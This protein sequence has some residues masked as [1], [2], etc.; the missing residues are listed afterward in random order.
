MRTWVKALDWIG[1]AIFG[2]GALA[3]ARYPQA[4]P[5]VMAIHLLPLGTAL[6]AFRRD[7]SRLAVLVALGLNGLW[8]AGLSAGVTSSCGRFRVVKVCSLRSSLLCWQHLACS[9]SSP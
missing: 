7:S 8:M 1:V 3:M 2:V 6:I 9:I 5:L 4:S